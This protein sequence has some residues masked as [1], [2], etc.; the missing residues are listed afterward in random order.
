MI[1]CRKSNKIRKRLTDFYEYFE[2]GAVRSCVILVDFEKMVQNDMWLQKSASIQKRTSPRKFDYFRQ[3]KPDFTA[4]DLS[5]KVAARPK[6]L[7]KRRDG[8][9]YDDRNGLEFNFAGR[10][11]DH[12]A[13]E[14]F[15][16]LECPQGAS[17][18][19][20]DL[21]ENLAFTVKGLPERNFRARVGGAC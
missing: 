6:R 17:V 10:L 4:S 18:A 9:P 14:L 12:N 8:N 11:D 15:A 3:L 20:L 7:P 1:V 13:A 2:L 5:T 21:Y 19:S 16:N